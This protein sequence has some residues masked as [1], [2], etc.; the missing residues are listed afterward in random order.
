[1]SRRLIQIAVLLLV[2]AT[3]GL[4]ATVQGQSPE[5]TTL[6]QAAY[7]DIQMTFTEVQVVI[8][9]E[10]GAAFPL[11]HHGGPTLA[12]VLDGEITRVQDGEE[13]VFKAGESWT[14]TPA[15]IHSA[16]NATDVPAR[17]LATFLLPPGAVATTPEA[18]AEVP[19]IGPVITYRASFPDITMN[20]RFSIVQTVQ[21]FAP[22]AGL[23]RHEH[24][25]PALIM[26][27]E[28]AITLRESGEE[29]EYGV[30]ESWTEMPGSVYEVFNTSDAPARVAVTVLVPEGAE[31]TTTQEG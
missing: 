18:D 3:I 14:E 7:P 22:G 12:L 24:G 20:S 17:V 11:H 23:P 9:L 29:R 2:A 27:L 6:Y 30:G 25:G 1:M 21:E 15:N 5:P 19:A 26:V 4:A 10:P 13:T 16:Y 8:D 28:G 31:A